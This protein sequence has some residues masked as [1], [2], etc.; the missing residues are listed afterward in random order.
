MRKIKYIVLIFAAISAFF[1]CEIFDKDKTSHP[2]DGGINLEIDWSETAGQSPSTLRSRFVAAS[3]AHR[4]F[5]LAGN[6]NLLVVMPGEGTLYVYNEA[7]NISVSEGKA[8]VNS[9]QI[10]GMFYSYASPVFTERD[11]D[12][13]HTAVMN[14]QTG[15][16]K[17]SLAIKPAAML[18]KVKTVSAVLEGVY[19]ELDI[20]TDALSASTFINTPFTKSAYYAT[21]S[22][23]VLGFDP[24][25]RQNLKLEVELE[26][27]QKA[28]VTSD[29]TSQVSGFN[30]SKNALLSL[31]ADLYI[32]NETSPVVT[33]N[34]WERNTEIRY[35]SVF[36]S[37]IELA[38]SA[39]GASIEIITDQPAWEYGITAT[40][41]WLTAT[42]SDTQLTL[43]AVGN[44]S[45]VQRE[46]VVRISAGGL[47]ES[48]TVV[49]KN[50]VVS[51]A[52][53][54][55]DTVKLQS[56]TV[57]KGV[58][59]ILMGDGYTAKDMNRGT[60][61]YEKDMRA[62]ADHFFSVYP[63]TVYRDHFNVYM[64]AAVSAQ[65]GISN[66]STAKTINTKFESLW[67][68]GRSTG[69]D[70][71]DDMVV[72]Y[73]DAIADL[74]FANI[75][76]LTVI[77]PINASVY[78]GTCSMYY[79]YSFKTDY[80]NGF[81]ISMCPVGSDFDEVVTHE[82]GGHGF[83]KLTDEYVYYANETIPQEDIDLIKYVKTFGWYENVDFYSD[84]LLTSW[85]GFAGLSKYYMVG[86]FGGADL[87]GKGIWRPEYNSCMNDNVPYY[88]APSRWAQVRRIKKLAGINYTFSQFLQD[89]A[90]PAYPTAARRYVERDFIPL[91]P[92]KIKGMGKIRK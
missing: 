65:E 26:N 30:Q 29:L 83:A 84:I 21:A 32:S 45:N 38:S 41:D 86:T 3:G 90:V 76:D 72:E 8:R 50:R 23:R 17:I 33:V 62:A 44:E 6:N 52:Y 37:E 47:N 88:N 15:E 49:Q 22:V 14:Q 9:T 42:K 48:V 58:N 46:A 69:I 24:A 34:K 89:D 59:L 2:N 13:A 1:G 36:P 66:K 40:G 73:V 61:K 7:E 85:K 55:K 19:S 64:V 67:E 53:L 80:G 56:A 82:A 18:D 92:P 57:G 74:A 27:G 87:Y 25:S 4:D 70:C 68:G 71:N 81:S 20:R 79:D 35:L 31:N 91:A 39:S 77:M 28:N 12:I 63:Y 10:P 16:L 78:A 54:D 11:R 5:N 75:H 43:S 51:P 60:G